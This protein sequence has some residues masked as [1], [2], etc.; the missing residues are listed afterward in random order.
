MQVQSLVRV[1][2]GV[3]HFL[4]ILWC[5]RASIVGPNVDQPFV[6]RRN[7]EGIFKPPIFVFEIPQSVALSK[8]LRTIGECETQLGVKCFKHRSRTLLMSQEFLWC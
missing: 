1:A 8:V 4:L 6:N 3:P 5:D 7:E 2:F